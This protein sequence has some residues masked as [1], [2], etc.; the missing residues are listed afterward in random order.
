MFKQLTFPQDS[1]KDM[2]Q[3]YTEENLFTSDE[4]LW[5]E[6]N[7][8]DIPL[9]SGT[10]ERGDHTEDHSLRY[11]DIRWL[12]YDM[13]PK[14]D[15]LYNRIQQSIERANQLW[16]FN[17]YSTPD[18]IQH[19]EYTSGGG[20]YDWHMDIGGSALSLRKVS[21]TVQLSD[22]NSYEGGDLQIFRSPQPETAPRNLGQVVIFPSY[23]MHRV[24]EIT[25][26]TRKSLVLWVGGEHYK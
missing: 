9:E 8:Q 22:P 14:F 25:K 13:Y 5:I 4:I 12:R 11:S 26:G 1:T 7:I 10:I 17:L 15:W 6:N 24:T 23:M 3:Y 19:T 21:V 16:G 2:A 20:H 18:H